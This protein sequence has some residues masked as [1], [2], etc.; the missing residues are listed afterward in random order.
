MSVIGIDL[1]LTG[2]GIIKLQDGKITNQKLIKSKPNGDLPIDELKRIMEIR[3]SIAREIE[4]DI[5]SIIQLVAIE[6]LAFMARNTT[7]LV[8]LSGLNYMI[9]EKLYS[10]KI[11]FV[12]VAPTSL[13]KF[14]TG[15]GNIAK[16]MMLL[17]TYKKYKVYFTDNNL[18]DA[19]GLAMIANSLVS[20]EKIPKHQQEVVNLLKKQL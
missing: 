2:T 17:E 14:I 12:I 6:G 16:E 8:Q 10:L 18:C 4:T 7:A 15:K 13:K 11:P 20:F 3:E 1:S 5:N 19:Y 9:R